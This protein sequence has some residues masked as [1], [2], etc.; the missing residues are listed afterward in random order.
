[1]SGLKNFP[2]LVDSHKTDLAVFSKGRKKNEFMIRQCVPNG[3][4]FIDGKFVTRTKLN[5]IYIFHLING[6]I[7]HYSIVQ[8]EEWDSWSFDPYTYPEDWCNCCNDFLDEIELED[9]LSD[10]PFDF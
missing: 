7:D 5:A 9:N 1:M 3:R 4:L 2:N 8:K 6:K 10:D